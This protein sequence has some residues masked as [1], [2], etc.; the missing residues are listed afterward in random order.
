VQLPEPGDLGALGGLLGELGE[1]TVS[2]VVGE[3]LGVG[4]G[5]VEP[6]QRTLRR[7]PL[8]LALALAVVGPVVEGRLVV[9]V[10]P[11]LAAERVA[12]DE[13]EHVQ[14]DVGDDGEGPDGA[15]PAPADALHLAELPVGVH[16]DAGGHQLRGEEGEHE[17]EARALHEG[18]APGTRHEDERLAD[19]AHL[20]VQRCH[21][22]VVV[23]LDRPHAESFLRQLNAA[24]LR[25]FYLRIHRSR[26]EGTDRKKK[27]TVP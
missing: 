18:P 13:L 16:G 11:G 27:V 6:V 19:D 23:L 5:L 21:Q 7:G 22:L 17:E 1:L 20:E 3:E 4:A 2:G 14:G 25:L 15:A 10:V 8:R 9:D 26:Q 12:D 24:L